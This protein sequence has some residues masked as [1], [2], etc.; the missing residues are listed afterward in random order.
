MIQDRAKPE[1]PP[2]ALNK[3][4]RCYCRLV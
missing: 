2:E 3:P 4:L 1:K